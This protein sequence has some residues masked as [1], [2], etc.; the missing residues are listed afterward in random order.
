MRAR[1]EKHWGFFMCVLNTEAA[2][3]GCVGSSVSVLEI[4]G[5]LIFD[6]MRRTWNRIGFSQMGGKE[7]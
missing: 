5:V 2:Q 6:M 1:S 7:K 3:V 4:T